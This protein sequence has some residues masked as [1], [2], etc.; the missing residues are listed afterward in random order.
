MQSQADQ[1][2]RAVHK[3]IAEIDALDRWRDRIA[4]RIIVIFVAGFVLAVGLL[5]WMVGHAQRYVAAPSRVSA[6]PDSGKA[7]SAGQASANR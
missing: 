1:E 5:A 3:L 7:S 2:T 6:S 4:R